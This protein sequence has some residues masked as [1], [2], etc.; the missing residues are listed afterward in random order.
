MSTDGST[1][2]NYPLLSQIEATGLQPDFWYWGHIHLGLVYGDQSAVSNA[3]SKGTI[4]ARCVGHSAIP[5]G[6]PWGLST[7]NNIID[8][9]A[10]TAV[11]GSSLVE[12]GLAMLTLGSDGSIKEQ[13]FNGV[14]PGDTTEK[15]KQIWINTDSKITR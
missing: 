13:F 9:I 12:N 15:P 4:K 2:D 14:T 6:S 11:T 3:S 8:F 7:G 1:V 5:F 10:D